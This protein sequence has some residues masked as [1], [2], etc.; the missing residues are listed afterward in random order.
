MVRTIGSS[1]PRCVKEWWNFGESAVW[2]RSI[3]KPDQLGALAQFPLAA[4][5]QATAPC[6]TKRRMRAA[7]PQVSP[8]ATAYG[9]R[10][11]R[12]ALLLNR[13]AWS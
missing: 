2:Q 8:P 12:E 3:K 9:P 7:G 6:L 5:A 4:S 13:Q 11:I 1:D 10:A